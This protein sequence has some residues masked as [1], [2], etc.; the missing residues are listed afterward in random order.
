VQ[1]IFDDENSSKP[2]VPEEDERQRL[3]KEFIYWSFV[4][5]HPA[6]GMV[7]P[8]ARREAMEGLTWTYAGKF[9]FSSWGQ[10]AND[11]QIESRKARN[12]FL[13]LSPKKNASHSFDC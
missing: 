12:R 4:E 10:K 6:H 11:C 7:S 2:M 8:D 9:A 1:P 3:A 5:K 13:P